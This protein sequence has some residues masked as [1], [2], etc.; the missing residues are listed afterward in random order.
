MT[1][2]FIYYYIRRLNKQYYPNNLLGFKNKIHLLHFKIVF[3]NG[4]LI[5][6]TNLLFYPIRL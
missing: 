1:D 5:Y 6:I 2:N 3:N 4:L